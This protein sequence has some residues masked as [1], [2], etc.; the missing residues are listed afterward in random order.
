M[1]KWHEGAPPDDIDVSEDP[2]LESHEKDLTL[3]TTKTEDGFTSHTDVATIARWFIKHPAV[4]VYRWRERDGECV[5][6]TARLPRGLVKLQA[7]PR[8]SDRFSGLV[9]SGELRGRG[10]G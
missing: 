8:Q 3:T 4:E 1:A 5:G 9:S 7:K 2:D 6:C 10:G